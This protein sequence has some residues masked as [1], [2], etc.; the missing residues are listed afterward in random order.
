[1]GLGLHEAEAPDMV[2]ILRSQ[3]DTALGIS[4]VYCVAIDHLNAKEI[5]KL[6]LSLNRLAETGTWDYLELK[7]EMQDLAAEFGT[8]FSIP[9]FDTSELDIILQ[10]DLDTAHLAAAERVPTIQQKAV[11]DGQ[12]APTL[13]FPV[14]L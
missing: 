8:D 2:G 5:R 6:R 4:E 11:I 13:E 10:D 3:P 12:A 9:G 7:I 14:P 1:M